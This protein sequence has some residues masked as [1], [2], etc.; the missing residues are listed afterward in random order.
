M[1]SCQRHRDAAQLTVLEA[2]HLRARLGR[3]EV[4]VAKHHPAQARSQIVVGWP[5][6]VTVDQGARSRRDQRLAGR[7]RL[8]VGIACPRLLAPDLRLVTLFAQLA[9]Q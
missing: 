9:G 8:D 1:A 6:R 4:P 5:V 2:Q 3:V 7:L